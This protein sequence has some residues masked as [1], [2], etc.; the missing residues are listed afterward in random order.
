MT[1]PSE[2]ITGIVGSIVAAVV[3]ILTAY[4]VDVPPAVSAGAIVIV[5]WIAAGVTWF[6]SR[7][8]QAGQL[9]SD[10]TGKVVAPE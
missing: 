7:K 4:G 8:Q 5:G 9:L 3:G 6:I 10:A 1:R 2:T